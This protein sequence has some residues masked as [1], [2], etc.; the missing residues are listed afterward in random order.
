MSCGLATIIGSAV[1]VGATVAVDV[2]AGIAEFV[3]VGGGKV[4]SGVCVIELHAII[5]N[6]VATSNL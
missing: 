1:I 2:G 5:T 6:K 3:A 4:G